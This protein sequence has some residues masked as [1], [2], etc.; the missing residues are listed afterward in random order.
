MVPES[1]I[2]PLVNIRDQLLLCSTH[3]KHRPVRSN[4]ARVEL[5]AA[6]AEQSVKRYHML[7]WMVYIWKGL[8]P[9]QWSETVDF[10]FD[11]NQF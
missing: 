3:S 8:E 10:R 7:L 1:M 2:F 4:L 11:V 6:G 9:S 5:P